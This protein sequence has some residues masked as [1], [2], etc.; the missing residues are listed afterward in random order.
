MN[1]NLILNFV[2]TL[3][4]SLK[5]GNDMK[6]HQDY[7]IFEGDNTSAYMFRDTRIL[8]LYLR[9]PDSTA[10]DSTAEDSTAE[11]YLTA[12]FPTTGGT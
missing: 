7:F 3:S 6:I 11:L 4:F 9:V 8:Y 1:F 2:P 10:K 12:T 5:F